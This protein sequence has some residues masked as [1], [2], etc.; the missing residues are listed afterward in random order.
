MSVVD[1]DKVDA[2]GTDKDEDALRLMIA[3]HLGW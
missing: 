2:V 1:L 3:D